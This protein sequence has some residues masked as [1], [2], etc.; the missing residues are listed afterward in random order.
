MSSIQ[1]NSLVGKKKKD[2][3]YL[4][5]TPTVTYDLASG[6]PIPE[7]I[8]KYYIQQ[9]LPVRKQSLAAA[10]NQTK[11]ELKK[12][13]LQQQRMP[14]PMRNSS[15]P[16]KIKTEDM[17]V[18]IQVE[19]ATPTSPQYHGNSQSCPSF[20]VSDSVESLTVGNTFDH[21]KHFNE[22]SDDDEDDEFNFK[23]RPPSSIICIKPMD[24]SDTD[25]EDEDNDEQD[26]GMMLDEALTEIVESWD[27]G[28][29]TT[30]SI[31]A[32]VSPDSGRRKGSIGGNVYLYTTVMY[33]LES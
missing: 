31:I 4:K 5:R 24:P 23:D 28:E 1:S 3:L 20:D 19:S 11:S 10:N 16:I 15:I 22:Q 9:Q 29:S 33:R 27:G 18:A 30:D 14:S 17:D 7:A 8:K 26:K 32:S 2:I 6:S 21:I 12:R 13:A 25:D